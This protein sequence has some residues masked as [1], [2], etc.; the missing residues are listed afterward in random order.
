M[1]GAGPISASP[2]QGTLGWL[3]IVRLGLVQ[4]ALGAIVVLT[5]STIN[6]VMVVELAMP[7]ALPG[8]LVALH[9]ALQVLRPRFGHGSDQGAR[10]TAWIIGGMAVLAAGGLG[11]AAATAWMATAPLFGVAAAV[12]AFVCIGLGVGAAGTTVLVLLADRVEPDRRAPAA[13]IVWV[14]MIAGMAVTAGLAGHFLDPFSPTRLVAVTAVVVGAA[15]VT[16]ALAVWGVDGPADQPAHQRS[17][18]PPVATSSFRDALSRAWAE[19]AAR[20][21]TVFIFVSMLAYSAQELIL[22]PFAGAVLSL[23]PGQS[24]QLSGIQHGGVLA[25]MVMVALAGSALAGGRFGSLRTWT[26]GGCLG[27][28]LALLGLVAAGLTGPAWPLRPSV[29]LLGLAN[30]AFAVA[31]I[32]SMMALAGRDRAAGAGV[33]MGMWG[34]AQAVAFGL[35]GLLGTV[36][37]DLTRHLLGAPAAAYP[38][39]FLGEAVLF[40]VA[41]WLAARLERPRRAHGMGQGSVVGASYAVGI[42]GR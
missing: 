7:A 12:V 2:I 15:L 41:G 29:F 21:F 6:R 8:A 20:R 3:G 5:T 38:I 27:S 26:I 17:E 25:G 18:L 31:A 1:S 36:A 9:Y 19:P 14:M 37:V 28:A 13:T 34:A 10:R 30:G 35:G 33:R 23:T 40:V 16:T 22:E 42:A 39:V 24:T 4:A 11:A 32:G